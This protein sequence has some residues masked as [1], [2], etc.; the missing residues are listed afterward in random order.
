[1]TIVNDHHEN[2]KPD[3]NVGF[4]FIK[5]LFWHKIFGTTLKYDCNFI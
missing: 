5:W 3:S 1:M 4:L 2:E